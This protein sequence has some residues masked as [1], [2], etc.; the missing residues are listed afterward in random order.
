MVRQTVKPPSWALI[1]F[2]NLKRFLLPGAVV[3]TLLVL[4]DS[5]TLAPG[6]GMQTEPLGPIKPPSLG[7]TLG[8]E[9]ESTT[10]P[11]TFPTNL[12]AALQGMSVPLLGS[13]LGGDG[14]TLSTVRDFFQP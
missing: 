13:V 7:R 4:S 8:R 1:N 2:Y 5:G 12:S 6:L 14:S 9:P 10:T 3:L 11:S